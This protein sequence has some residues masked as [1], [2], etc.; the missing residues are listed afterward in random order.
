[1]GKANELESNLTGTFRHSCSRLIAAV[2][3][4]ERQALKAKHEACI[5][6]LVPEVKT[7]VVLIMGKKSQK[8]KNVLD[9]ERS[10]TPSSSKS[11][12]SSPDS[13]ASSPARTKT[14]SSQKKSGRTPKSL[15]GSKTGTPA[16]SRASSVSLSTKKK[17]K[18]KSPAKPK[19]KTKV[20][21][22]VKAKL[23]CTICGLGFN[24]PSDL[25]RHYSVGHYKR[26]LVDEYGD[27]CKTCNRDFEGSSQAAAHFG[28][29]HG[30]VKKYL[31]EDAC[32]KTAVE[33][34]DDVDEEEENEEV[35]A[36]RQDP[37][38]DITDVDS[39]AVETIDDV[40]EEEEN[41]EVTASRQETIDDVD[42][43]EENEEVTASR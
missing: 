29:K 30:H 16:G 18:G 25:D 21:A 39:T 15:K 40:D 1:M 41:E 31:K 3:E 19:L 9:A 14:K 24:Y 11:R 10:S 6:R 17:K 27:F 7:L 5:K 42:E 23:M 36:S 13:R 37:V 20:K 2:P 28:Q 32:I 43:E 4:Q 35:T 8:P 34:I 33:T 26:D 22:K 12:L 38:P